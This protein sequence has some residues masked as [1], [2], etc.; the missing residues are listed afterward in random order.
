MFLAMS[1]AMFLAIEH[2]G[3]S[4]DLGAREFAA[5]SGRKRFEPQVADS[6]TLDFFDGMARLKKL[7][8]QRIAARFR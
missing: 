4:V 5:L 2:T 3:E 7:I 8:P 6:D 1:L